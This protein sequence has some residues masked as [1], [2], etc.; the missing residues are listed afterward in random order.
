[1]IVPIFN[2]ERF[3]GEALFSLR[4]EQDLEAEFIVLDDGSTDGSV[5]RV[6]ALAQQDP[7]IRLIIGEHRGVSATRNVGVR[8]ATGKYITFLDCDDICPPGRIARQVLKLASHPDAAAVIGETLWFEAL[9][10]DLDPV[11]GTRQ[12]RSLGVHLHSALFHRS[13]FETYGVFDETLEAGEDLDFFLRLLEGGSRFIVETEIASLYRRHSGNM[14][15]NTQLLQK[16]MVAAFQRSIARR[17]TVGRSAPLDLFF[18]RRFTMDTIFSSAG[19]E[20][21]APAGAPACDQLEQ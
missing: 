9:T 17:R 18:M 14:T 19:S 7:R 20:C 2:G 8:A 16:A 1:M 15:R 10:P 13:V 5:G 4:R 6:K 11:P 21:V 12:A 3:I